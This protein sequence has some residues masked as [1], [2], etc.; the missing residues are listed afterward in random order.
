MAVT[1]DNEKFREDPDW[2]YQLEDIAAL[3]RPP[4]R[5][6]ARIGC[7]IYGALILLL[8]A[9]PYLFGKVVRLHGR[10]GWSSNPITVAGSGAVAFGVFLVGLA[11]YV[12]FLCYWPYRNSLVSGGGKLVSFLVAAGGFA[13]FMWKMIVK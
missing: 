2:V 3:G 12:H 4:N 8:I 7:G 11:G 10:F 9:R 13:F 5:G 6:W 1:E